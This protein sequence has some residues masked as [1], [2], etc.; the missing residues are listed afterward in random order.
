[1]VYHPGIKRYLLALGFSMRG[2]GWGIFEAPEPWGPWST[3]FITESWGL[4]DTHS[5]RLPSKWIDAN[6]NKMYLVF[7]GRD[8]RGT[9]YDAFCVR[10]VIL[11]LKS[12]YNRTIPNSSASK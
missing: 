8:D 4:G 5:Y 10:K 11:E 6:S 7:S 12:D 9:D 3:A 2:G 1:V